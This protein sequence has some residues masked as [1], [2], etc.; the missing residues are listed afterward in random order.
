M[1]M[2]ISNPWYRCFESC[3]SFLAE[4]GLC[5]QG[6][7]EVKGVILRLQ[8]DSS[9]QNDRYAVMTSVDN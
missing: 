9:A 4:V 7:F 5:F 6:H 3:L 2:F 1:M 8:G